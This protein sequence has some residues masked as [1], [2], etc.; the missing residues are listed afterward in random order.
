MATKSYHPSAIVDNAAPP[1]YPDVDS[2]G[3]SRI[4]RKLRRKALD[5][6]RVA[7][8]RYEGRP[9]KSGPPIPNSEKHG[10]R[11]FYSMDQ[12]RR[13]W[14]RSL[15]V[16]QSE[17]KPKYDQ[18]KRLRFA[19]RL[20]REIAEI[21]GYS[22]GHV[23]KIVRGKIRRPRAASLRAAAGGDNANANAMPIW[24]KHG[25][26]TLTLAVLYRGWSLRQSY[27]PGLSPPEHHHWISLFATNQARIIGRRGK[28]PSAG[29]LGA[30]DS[31]SGIALG[32]ALLAQVELA[33]L[34]IEDAVREVN[35]AFGWR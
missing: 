21:V 5:A 6:Y 33:G 34:P 35:F 3:T 1:V 10:R 22:I 2:L 28:R 18:C 23:S 12:A 24:A 4:G 15:Q 17:A 11:E 27:A 14:L 32:M 7:L 8:R 9:A 26:R 25:S 31:T 29:Y 30:L 13:G 16:R 19:G 20:L